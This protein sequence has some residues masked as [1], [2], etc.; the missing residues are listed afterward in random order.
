MSVPYALQSKKADNGITLAQA[1]EIRVNTLKTG[2]TS[3]ESIAIT[4]NKES[5]AGEIVR[6]KSLEDGL[7]VLQVSVMRIQM[8]LNLYWVSVDTSISFLIK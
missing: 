5:I 7:N 3:E 2:I 6:V 1:S 8:T 4:T